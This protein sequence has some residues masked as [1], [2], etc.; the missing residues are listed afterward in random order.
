MN[1]F[2]LVQIL[3]ETHSRFARCGFQ[4]QRRQWLFGYPTNI[5][6]ATY[7]FMENHT[8]Y[9]FATGIYYDELDD[10]SDPEQ[11]KELWI[12]ATREKEEAWIAEN[13]DLI[14]ERS[15]KPKQIWP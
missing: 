10:I 4:I 6:W 3:P 1:N 12:K 9:Y 8:N 13:A 11:V 14:A 7:T 2:R 15:W 5:W